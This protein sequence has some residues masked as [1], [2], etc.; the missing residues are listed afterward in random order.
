MNFFDIAVLITAA[1]AAAIDIKTRKI[2]NWLT[3]TMAASGMVGSL[4]VFGWPGLAFSAKGWAVGMLVFFIPFLLRVMGGGDV[5]LMGAI[6][7][8]KG[9]GFVLE[10]ALFGAIWG[11]LMAITALIVKK[12]T[13]YLESFG[14]GLKLFFLTR[15]QA[16]K[17]L[18]LPDDNNKHKGLYLP[19]G[20]AIF[21][22]V[23]TSY[24]VEL[25]I[26]L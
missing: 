12:R 7:A 15:G 16:G 19:Y 11:G 25:K 3:V 17:E 26:N 21:L 6:G 8:L 10:T 23:I 20:V 5:K 24:L 13:G 14:T 1:I 2:P 9:A 4:L 22:G 18:L